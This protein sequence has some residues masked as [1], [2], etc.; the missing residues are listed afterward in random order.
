MLDVASSGTGYYFD[1]IVDAT[2]IR[3]YNGAKNNNRL[4]KEST[5]LSIMTAILILI[6]LITSIKI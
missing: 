5:L 6:T 2:E 3:D 4:R 1:A